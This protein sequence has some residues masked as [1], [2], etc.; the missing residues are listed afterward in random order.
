MWTTPRPKPIRETQEILLIDGVQHLNQRPLDDLVLQRGDPERPLPPVRLRY[1]HPPSRYHPVRAP[2]HTSMKLLEVLLKVMPVLAPRHPIDPWS[3][4]RSDRPVCRPET[5][6]G[7]VVQERGEPCLLVLPC[8]LTHTIQLTAHAH[9]GSASGAR[10]AGRVPLGRP[11][12]L[13][14]LRSPTSSI[15]RQLR[16]YYEAV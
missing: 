9:S 16:R 8:C 7:D 11:P 3:S 1:E 12:F 6:N 14:H 2:M 4:V 5:I 10:F 13:H 15:V